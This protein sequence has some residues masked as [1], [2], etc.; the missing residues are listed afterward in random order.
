MCKKKSFSAVIDPDPGIMEQNRHFDFL[1][2]ASFFESNI[3]HT[4]RND[5][6]T[7]YKWGYLA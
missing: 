3:K 4:V 7:I 6:E 1:F 2:S 5:L